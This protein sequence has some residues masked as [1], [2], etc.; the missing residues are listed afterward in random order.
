V[1]FA[2]QGG[3]VASASDD[4]TIRLWSV[5]RALPNDRVLRGHQ[6]PV[7]RIQ[8]DG[9][10][11]LLASSSYDD[12]VRLW[13]VPSGTPQ[14]SPLSGEPQSGQ[15]GMA[16]T[17][18][19]KRIASGAG[20][21]LIRLWD[22]DSATP[23]G[24][25]FQVDEAVILDL[26]FSPDGRTLA[27]GSFDKTV[28]LWDVENQQ[29]LGDPLLGH[30]DRVTAVQFS[31]DG[32]CLATADAGGSVRLWYAEP[33]H[34]RMDEIRERMRQ[35]SDLR[36]Q[37][38]EQVASVGTSGAGLLEFQRALLA[39]PRF[40]GGLRVP[41]LILVGE[42]ARDEQAGRSKLHSPSIPRP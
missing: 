29:E 25:P 16:L 26:A 21:H 17:L 10:G 41:A 36:K 23:I 7:K 27:G 35:V 33:L 30:S 38:A 13:H 11:E 42:L 24:E 19:G 6:R 9:S 28:R 1:Q 39:D 15:C 22:V 31:P 20:R 40:A 37:L 4:A 2:P 8:F 5:D 14:G 32:S 34:A 12:T 3:I 18:D